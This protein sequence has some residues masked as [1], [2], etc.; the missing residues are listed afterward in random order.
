MIA[1]VNSKGSFGAFVQF[2]FELYVGD[3][4]RFRFERSIKKGVLVIAVGERE[5]DLSEV[6]SGETGSHGRGAG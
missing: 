2:R 6:V 1:Y 4:S 3:S 5:M